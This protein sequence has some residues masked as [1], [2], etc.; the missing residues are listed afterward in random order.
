MKL[1]TYVILLAALCVSLHGQVFYFSQST[2][3]TTVTPVN[4]IHC[5]AAGPPQTHAANS[6]IRT[7]DVFG[8]GG[9]STIDICSVRFGVE[10]ALA[11]LGAG[12]QP[13]EIRLYVVPT[14]GFTFP[15]AMSSL[16]PVHT[17]FFQLADTTG[18]ANLVIDQPITAFP[19]VTAAVTDTVIVE[20]FSPD[21]TAPQNV[22][23]IGSN[24]AGESAPGYLEAAACGIAVPQTT[25]SLAPTPMH[26]ILDLGYQFTGTPLTLTL[27]SPAVTQLDVSIGGMIPGL[28]YY[29]IY[30]LVPCPVLGSGPYLGLCETNL[31]NLLVQLQVPP[32]LFPL[33]FNA[34]GCV[35]SQSFTG[36]F[37]GLYLEAVTFGLA[38]GALA[39]QSAVTAV[40]IL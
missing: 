27:T 17:E 21:G 14:A 5:G 26:M 39:G 8:S 33:H 28:E 31:N 1:A 34:T 4:S 16:T 3:N 22:F 11:G 15:V 24:T 9:I 23:F 36:L 6:Y 25:V 13:M 40:T 29:T 20:L 10:F 30:S 18:A 37:S 12:S 19:P 38:G 35:Q 7:Y 2:D 32:V